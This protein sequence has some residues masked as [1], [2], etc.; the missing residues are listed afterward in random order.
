MKRFSAVVGLVVGLGILTCYPGSALTL[1]FANVTR[2]NIEFDGTGDNFFFNPGMRAS[3]FQITQSDGLADS[4]GDLGN[5]HGIF[6][7]GSITDHGNGLLTAPVTGLGTITVHDGMGQDLTAVLAWSEIQTLGT[8][9][10]VNLSGIINLSG[11][12]Y[13]GIQSDLIGLAA[14]TIGTAVLSFTFIPG[15]SLYNLTQ[16]GKVNQASFSGT[17]AD[18]PVRVPDG[19]ATLILL[20]AAFCALAAGWK[21]DFKPGRT[22]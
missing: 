12:T 3:Q 6:H 1:N 13:A 14:P 17:L 2:A 8:A 5:I 10:S 18:S 20:G 15:R 19:G 9:G 4:V 11:I 16:N 22:P 7:I 21:R